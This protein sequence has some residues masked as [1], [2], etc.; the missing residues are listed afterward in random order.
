MVAEKAEGEA[1]AGVNKSVNKGLGIVLA[2][3]LA[4]LP[5]GCWGKSEVEELGFVLAIGIDPGSSPGTFK[6]TYQMGIPK[7]VGDSGGNIDNL[8]FTVEAMSVRDSVEKVYNISSRRPFV[9]TVKLILVGEEQARK[10]VN[11]VIDFFQRYY[12]FRRTT[13]IAIAKGGAAELLNVKTRK[14]KLPALSMQ[15]FIQQADATSI[16]PIVRL[17]HYLTVLATGSTAPVIPAAESVKPG[18]KGIDYASEKPGEAEELHMEGAG[19]LK[20]DRLVDFLSK[21]ETE[22][23][24]WLQNEIKQRFISTKLPQYGKECFASARIITTKTNWKLEQTGEGLEIHYTVTGKWDL[25]EI[26][27]LQEALQ[28]SEWIGNVV[29]SINDAFSEVVKQ[30]CEAALVKQRELGLDFLGIGRHIDQKKPS[31]WREIRD[32]WDKMIVDMPVK[33]DVV[34]SNENAGSSFGPPTNQPGSGQQ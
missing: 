22:G 28:P 3:S 14:G 30:E 10:G 31:Y 33:V 32:K 15:G 1:E 5:A 6:V 4:L 29:P 26:Y 12:E 27:G 2:I 34:L 24:M 8:T 7:K 23:Y 9:G 18:E 19:V 20:G 21:K 16:F 17:G 11:Q 13:F 25:D